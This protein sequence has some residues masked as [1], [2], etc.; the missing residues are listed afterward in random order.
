[1]TV[2]AVATAAPEGEVQMGD[3]RRE[4]EDDI[5]TPIATATTVIITY[6]NYHYYYSCFH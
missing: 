6:Y 2:V 5:Y 4:V 1:M 3:E